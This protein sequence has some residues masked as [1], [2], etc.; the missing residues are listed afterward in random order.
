LLLAAKARDNAAWSRL[1]ETFR[2][3]V[4]RWFRR[5]WRISQ[6]AADDLVQNVLL[7]ALAGLSAFQRHREGQSFTGWLWVI[8]RNEAAD[9]FS[10]RARAE[11]AQGGTDHQHFVAELPDVPPTDDEQ[12]IEL[13]LNRLLELVRCDFSDS[14]KTIFERVIV[15]GESASE[16]AADLAMNASAVRE[17]K[18]R[19]LRR[20]REEWQYLFGEWPFAPYPGGSHDG[21]GP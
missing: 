16:V 7:R 19:V 3:I 13:K 4:H 8:A 17:A 14:T 12:D 21:A 2:P 10:S 15:G 6:P 18:R 1:D 20:L 5:R 9:Y 11:A